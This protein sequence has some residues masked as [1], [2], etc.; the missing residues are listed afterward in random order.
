MTRLWRR[1]VAIAE[2]SDSTPLPPSADAHIC[3]NC[4]DQMRVQPKCR[5]CSRSGSNRVMASDLCVDEML[6]RQSARDMNTSWNRDVEFTKLQSELSTLEK[7]LA[8]R[9]SQSTHEDIDWN[10]KPKEASAAL[11]EKTTALESMITA[12]N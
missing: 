12:L 5:T 8:Q 10:Q 7:T 3:S 6:E 4:V 2:Q 1:C 11:E 9:E